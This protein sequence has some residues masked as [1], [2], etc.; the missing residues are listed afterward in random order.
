MQ[1]LVHFILPKT[2]FLFFKFIVTFYLIVTTHS[3]ISY[4]NLHLY[5]FIYLILIF[6]SI[7]VYIPKYIF[8]TQCS[9]NC[10]F[11]VMTTWYCVINSFPLFWR[12]HFFLLSVF[13]TYMLR[14]FCV[15]FFRRPCGPFFV[16]S[17]HGYLLLSWLSTYLGSHILKLHG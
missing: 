13:L 1:A 9:L 4:I 3:F 10:M 14:V 17:W 2:P 6:I 12:K 15:L 7:S 16:Y 11:S 5:L 8:L